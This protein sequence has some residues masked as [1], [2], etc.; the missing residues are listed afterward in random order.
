MNSNWKRI[1]SKLVDTQAILDK[2]NKEFRKL[3]KEKQRIA[4]CQDA[5]QQIQKGIFI[6]TE[7]TYVQDGVF[8]DLIGETETQQCLLTSNTRCQACALGSLFLSG[9]RFKNSVSGNELEEYDNYGIKNYFN[10]LFDSSNLSLVECA[11]EKDE[12]FA[13]GAY[14]RVYNYDTSKY[15]IHEITIK[16]IDFG[17]KYKKPKERL[18]AILKNMIKNKGVFKP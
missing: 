15:V 11:F 14:Q 9:V 2:A 17:K 13:S 7:R 18:V 4:I 16:A 10:G 1:V 8:S 3:S 6:P 12:A 5:L